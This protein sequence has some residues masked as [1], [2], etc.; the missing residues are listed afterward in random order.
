MMR[1]RLSIKLF[2]AFFLI[3]AM[4]VCAL[5]L[6]RYLS[7]RNVAHFMHQLDLQR[8][9]PL[10]PLLQEEYR[11]LD[12]WDGF[13]KDPR[14][15]DHLLRRSPEM[16]RSFR[17]PLPPN[18]APPSPH[19]GP[20]P[21]PHGG[22]PSR[23]FLLDANRLTVVGKPE[24]G[25]KDQMI[26]I[27]VDGRT[28]GYLGMTHLEPFGSGP[29]AAL[30]Q[31]QT[32]QFYLL[33]AGLIA[34]TALIALLFSRHLLVPIRRLMRGTEALADR[35]FTIRIR[36]T[37]GDE[38]GQLAKNFNVM[39][40]TL[41]NYEQMRRQWLTDIS[42]ELRTPLAVLRGEIEGIL[43]GIREPTPDNLSSLHGEILRI[44][45]IVEDLH[46]LSMADADRL[47]LN[48]Q[49][50]LPATILDPIAAIYQP[51][52]ERCGLQLELKL[53]DTKTAWIDGDADRL[54]QVFNNILNNAYKYV[55]PPGAL[56]IIG[57]VEE[58]QVRLSFRDTGPGVPEEALDRLFDRLF[59][60]DASR[61]RNTGGSGL[62]L[63]ICRDIIENHGG[64][65][66]AE[67]S[68][69]GGL[70]IEI[71]LPRSDGTSQ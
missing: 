1:I 46:L 53:D 3:L 63:S 35:N 12:N 62:G 52:F 10:V 14:R 42:H 60:V 29:P 2:L 65:I 43:D 68:V 45:K 4:S 40:Q 17:P 5:F 7:A 50:V 22:G 27:T 25:D 54:A 28:V 67:N 33:G 8:L 61:S 11:S 71:A 56:A 41:E 64:R 21:G 23:V 13:R 66:W 26:S 32:M 44:G 69:G 37:T 49:R 48:K 51:R 70:I 15:L 16:E 18:G 9:E 55:A 24:S 6:A 34:L 59:R 30:L 36:A 31:R 58:N 38:L 39:A 20:G 19:G 47:Q 57:R